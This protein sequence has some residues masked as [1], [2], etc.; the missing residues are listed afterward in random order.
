MEPIIAGAA[1]SSA[2]CPT[3]WSSDWSTKVVDRTDHNDAGHALDFPCGGCRTQDDPMVGTVANRLTERGS[4][5]KFED[6][7]D[8]LMI[9]E[10]ESTTGRRCSS[11]STTSHA[12]L[13]RDGVKDT[14]R[15]RTIFEVE[16]GE[17]KGNGP[18]GAMRVRSERATR[19]VPTFWCWS[20]GQCF[21]QRSRAVP[22][23]GATLGEAPGAWSRSRGSGVVLVCETTRTRMQRKQSRDRDPG[24]GNQHH[25]SR[26]DWRA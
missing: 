16:K 23:G 21:L 18:D 12:A 13:E 7:T 8:T 15:A 4:T 25:G 3:E 22:C 11:A 2:E 20:P 1:Q 24:R 5:V 6:S 10:K 26:S 14:P 9:E 19:C 17:D